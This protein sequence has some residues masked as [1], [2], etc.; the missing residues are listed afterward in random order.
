M[1][2]N[3]VK[4]LCDANVQCDNLIEA[5]RPDMVDANESKIKCVII[6]IA[7]SDD[8][9]VIKKEKEKVEKHQD[10]KSIRFGI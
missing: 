2:T 3:E 1:E 10:L 8:S 6:G 5:R 9:M 4:I 7:V